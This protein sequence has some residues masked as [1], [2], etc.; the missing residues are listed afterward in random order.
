MKRFAQLY[1]ELDASTSTRAKLEAM[2]RYFAD[3][4]PAEAAWAVYFLAGGKPRQLVGS[5]ALRE[6]AITASGLPEWLFVES[7]EAV[8]DLA[9]TVA[10]LLPPPVARSTLGLAQWMNQRLLPL[11]GD[12]PPVA[13][14]ALRSYVEEIDTR[15]RFVLIKLIGGGWR[16][17]VS[18]ALVTRA[19]A[20]FTHLDAKV[21]AQRLI[22]YSDDAARPDAEAFLALC[23]P[24]QGQRTAG[25]PYPFFLAH[26]LDAAPGALGPRDD[27]L[28]EW[29][30]DGVRAQ[31][32]RRE[33]KTW[34]WSR[35]E[36]LITERFP[37][38]GAAASTLPDGTVLDGEILVWDDD[39]PAPA[40]F[41]R[42]QTRITR[43]TVGSK[44]LREHPARF[45]AFD[46]LEHD[47]VDLRGLA[48]RQ[49]RARLESAV[50]HTGGRIV[51]APLID[52]SDWTALAGLRASSRSRG[53]EGL[54]LKHH[55]ARYG[56]GR[57]RESGTWWKWKIDPLSVDAVLVYA[58]RGHGRRASL[59]SDYTFAV[60]DRAPR[61]DG[62]A[63][64]ALDAIATSSAL[65]AAATGLPKLVPFA[66]A[67]SGLTD[68][69]IRRVDAVI[70]RTALEKFGPV[71]RVVPSL[72][73][74]IGFEGIQ[75]STRHQSGIAVRFP[76]M[77]RLRDDKPVHAA[78]TLQH[79]RALLRG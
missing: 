36:E 39:G 65:D 37:E 48:Q 44:M 34:L 71:R 68:V 46:L 9:E 79:L 69:E 19:L 3:A 18:R 10:L 21:I 53:L 56:V 59:Y 11:R 74:E 72:V 47:G 16:V 29:K 7:H 24:E 25:A 32:V 78:D 55:D 67:Y 31:L 38:I 33:G 12:P 28:A 77:L 45:I 5:R 1:A 51:V 35:G 6:F 2:H 23:A 14:Q 58:Q 66:K 15:E 8:G 49:R 42:L 64:A 22:G 50:V 13:V 75:A 61:D 4:A 26:Q 41:A 63:K 60:W 70:R 20:E 52:A 54:M 62:E 40:P 76:R 17:G 43:K 27:W 73:F 57:T 30:Y